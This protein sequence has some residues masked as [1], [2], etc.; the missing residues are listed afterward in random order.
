MQ[1][2]S[3]PTHNPSPN[4]RRGVDRRRNHRRLHPQ[5]LRGRRQ[6]PRRAGELAEAHHHDNHDGRIF[7]ATLAV[8][9][10]CVFDA[11]YTLLILQRGGEELNYV[12]D[13]L[14]RSSTFGFIA[15][16]YTVTALCLFVLVLFNR[17]K[18]RDQVPVRSIIYGALLIYIVLFSYELMIWPGPLGELFRV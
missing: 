12:M 7:W 15:I 11:H 1:A 6:G 5:A 4:V 18:F 10:L 14:I 8:L 17:Q 3:F 9:L 16:K 2:D 13:A